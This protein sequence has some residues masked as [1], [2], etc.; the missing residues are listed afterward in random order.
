MHERT[1]KRETESRTRGRAEKAAIYIYIYLYTCYLRKIN[2]FFSCFILC[3]FLNK[4]V[5]EQSR[6]N[7]GSLKTNIQSY[8][9]KMPSVVGC[10]KKWDRENCVCQR[11]ERNQN[12]KF[13]KGSRR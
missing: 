4:I 12:G 2:G 1:E 6:R 13:R 5:E 8:A 3:E 10:T 7:G 9:S 11:K